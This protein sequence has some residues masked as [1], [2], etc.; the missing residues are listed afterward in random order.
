MEGR[1][2]SHLGSAKMGCSEGGSLHQVQ[3]AS[4]ARQT[5]GGGTVWKMVTI[6]KEKKS[7]SEDLLLHRWALFLNSDLNSLSALCLNVGLWSGKI[8][9]WG[10][11]I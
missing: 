7:G 1:G 11:K 2:H 9:V 5:G 4:K 3:I 6:T 8:K 10:V